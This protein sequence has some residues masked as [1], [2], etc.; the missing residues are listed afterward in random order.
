MTKHIMIDLETWGTG[1]KAIPVSIGACRFNPMGGDI[2]DCFHVAIDPASAK[3]AGLEI[4]SDTLLW[5]LSKDRDA[6]REAWL[7]HK[8]V[9]L[10]SALTGFEDWLASDEYNLVWGN[11]AT[12]DNVILRSAF[13]AIQIPCPWKFWQDACY[14]TLKGLA[15]AIKIEHAGTHHDALDDAVDQAKHMQ[16]VVAHLGLQL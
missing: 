6:A 9:D 12:F 7:A 5:W 1:P 8:R 14:R 16:A 2:E 13:E 10:Y 15:P 3:A 4:S 11:G